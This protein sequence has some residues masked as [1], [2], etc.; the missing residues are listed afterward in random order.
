MEEE[1]EGSGGAGGSRSE[2]AWEVTENNRHREQGEDTRKRRRWVV[3]WGLVGVEPQEAF[4]TDTS[5]VRERRVMESEHWE[6]GLCPRPGPCEGLVLNE[7][8]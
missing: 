6:E 5:T 2:K 8:D 3:G 7:Q 1:A 4:V